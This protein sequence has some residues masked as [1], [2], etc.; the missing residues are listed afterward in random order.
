MEK[1]G[2]ALL[3]LLRSREE[4]TNVEGMSQSP[5]GCLP[6]PLTWQSSPEALGQAHS[7]FLFL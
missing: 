3:G 7:V 5:D 1:E 6:D 4:N 2:L